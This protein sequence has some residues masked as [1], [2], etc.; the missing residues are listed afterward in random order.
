MARVEAEFLEGKRVV[1]TA[2][3]RSQVNAREVLP[4]GPIGYSSGELLLIALANCSL[5]ILTNHE[6]M[7]DVPV[8]SCK[9]ILESESLSN[10]SRMDNIKVVIE[11]EVDDPTLLERRETLE[12]AADHCPVGNTLR[13]AP[14]VSV[15]LRMVAPGV[16]DKQPMAETAST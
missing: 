16:G 8:R 12:R 3:G 1:F 13:S 10:P 7:K 14:S 2:R 5:G 9:A 6:L 11:L 15:E 4:D